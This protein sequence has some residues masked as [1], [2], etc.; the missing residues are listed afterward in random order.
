[1][2]PDPDAAL[3]RVRAICLALPETS[4]KVSHGI[5]AFQVAGKMF[6]YFRHDHHGDRTTVVCVKTS[7]RE[8]QDMLIE[9]DPD[10][11]SWPAYIGPAGWIAVDIAPPGTDWA[12][13]EDRIV[14]SWEFAAPRRLL[15]AGGR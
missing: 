12:H 4:E 6:A 1:M 5:P 8:E 10:L 15:E 13:I 3:E 2:H 7:G 9:A 11:Y 14:R